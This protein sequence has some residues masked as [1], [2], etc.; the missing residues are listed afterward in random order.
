MSDRLTIDTYVTVDL[1]VNVRM[2]RY[3]EEWDLRAM[4]KQVMDEGVEHVKSV[5]NTS[6][7][8]GYT[9]KKITATGIVVEKERSM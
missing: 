6:R 9:I 3:N 5:F 1:T 4:F 7:I 8:S 2:S